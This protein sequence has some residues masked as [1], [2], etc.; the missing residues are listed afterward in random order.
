MDFR[1]VLLG[2]AKFS[3][4]WSAVQSV[5]SVR[6][7]PAACALSPSCSDMVPPSPNRQPTSSAPAPPVTPPQSRTIETSTHI[8][9]NLLADPPAIFWT[10]SEASSVLSS[11]RSVSRSCL[12]LRVSGCSDSLSTCG[13]AVLFVRNPA[14]PS[15]QTLRQPSVPGQP[16][17][18]VFA[19]RQQQFSHPIL[20]PYSPSPP[21]SNP[22]IRP[23]AQN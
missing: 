1:T 17:L 15:T 21:P 22:C 2:S 14:S 10:R 9:V 5:P 4:T 12:F 20:H 16:L 13:P 7:V 11:L 23:P 6:R 3:N 8:L 18:L 19:P